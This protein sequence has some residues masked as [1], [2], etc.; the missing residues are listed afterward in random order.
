M[1]DKHRLFRG[2]WRESPF[3]K[4]DLK[5]VILDLIQ[6]KPCYGYEVI[7]A[8]E[9][10]SHG[11]YTPSPGVIYPTLQML[12]EMGYA[13]VTEQEEKKVYAI[14]EEGRQFLAERQDLADKV[15]SRMRDYWHPDNTGV[16]GKMMHEFDGFRGLM[17]RRLRHA[18]PETMQRI[19]EVLS[20]AYQE[21]ETI[22]KE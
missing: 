12:E 16:F 15:K 8:I 14:T 19:R 21:I 3:H 22:L 17:R 13:S 11:L 7:R 9:E 18:D 4:G 1:F 2:T 20:K 10:R 6:D 5:H